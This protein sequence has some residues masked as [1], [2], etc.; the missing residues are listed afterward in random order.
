M[1]HVIDHVDQIT[2][3]W[4]TEVL[5][6][7]GA[8][9]QG[10]V[11]SVQKEAGPLASSMVFRLS[12]GY[13]DDASE[14]APKGLILKMPRP[15]KGHG[16]E[17]EIEFYNTI[18]GQMGDLPIIR[19]FDT[20]YDANTRRYHLLLDDLTDT[21]F[22]HPPTQLP[23]Q[24]IYSELVVDA[25]AHLHATWWDHDLLGKRIGVMPVEALIKGD[26]EESDMTWAGRTLPAFFDY[27]GDR[28]SKSRREVYARVL[29]SLGSRLLRRIRMG[30]GLTLVHGD[31][32][33]GNFLYPHHPDT[34]TVRFLDWK[35]WCVNIG[36]DD[37]AHMM[38]VFWFPER[39]ARMETE[40]L[41]RYHHQ[42]LECG[43]KDYSWQDC[44]EDY[45]LSVARFLFYPMLQWWWGNNADIWWH[46]LE[47]VHQAFHDL[48]CV[49]VLDD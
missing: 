28:L 7:E 18:G 29:S 10:R 44:W 16:V 46:H 9:I 33:I 34:D 12:L 1:D 45:R 21:H 47:R 15:G 22:S 26:I 48:K 37:L 36:P 17:K 35:S 32:H 11:L 2:P 25:L 4:L 13:S 41:K 8:L 20:A 42:L 5:Q 19:C 3:G 24:K 30:R 23:P 31:P 39:R 27:M 6:R 40:L 14:S 38:A 43:V 49:E